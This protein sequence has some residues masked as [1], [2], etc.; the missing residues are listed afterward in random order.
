MKSLMDAD[1]KYMHSTVTDIRKTF[2]RAR[3]EIT[4]AKRTQ[5]KP[6]KKESNDVVIP[7]RNRNP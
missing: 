4:R 6:A 2:K 7:I 5:E 1:F 3:A